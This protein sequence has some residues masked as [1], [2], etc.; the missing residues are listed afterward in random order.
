[1]NVV[2]Y[3]ATTASASRFAHACA[4]LATASSGERATV[5]AERK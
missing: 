1:V 5:P 2:E 4:Q 3:I